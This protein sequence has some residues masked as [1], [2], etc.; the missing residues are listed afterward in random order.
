MIP[1]RNIL[2][3]FRKAVFQPGYAFDVFCRRFR[4]YLGYLFLNGRGVFP[5]SITL[6][7]TSRC[8]LRCR[9][10]G[11]WGD[12]GITK[13][14]HTK[15]GEELTLD[16][17]K[18]MLDD[19]S[20]FMPNITLFGG[21]PLL[22]KGCVEL[23]RLCKLR[24]MHVCL[25]TNGTLLKDYA[26]KIVRY[27]LDEL[28]ISLD[29][30]EEVHDKIRGVPGMF[31][32]IVMG[33]NE[34]SNEKQRYKKR[35]PIVNLEFTITRYNLDYMAEMQ[36]VAGD[37]NADSLNF[38]H[39]IFIE[40]E[41]YKR[42]QKE[43]YTIFKSSS[44]AWK[45]FLLEGIKDIDIDRLSRNIQ[46]ITSNRHDFLV[47]IYPN[48]TSDELETYYR[49]PEKVPHG[50]KARCI[51]PWIVAYIFPNGDVRPCLNFDFSPGNIKKNSFRDIWNNETYIRFR[52]V[53]KRKGIFPVCTRCT[54]LY[55]Y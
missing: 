39:L 19:V 20:G 40:E 42:H 47:N 48:L 50:Y 32:K 6:F 16:E 38:H 46:E 53:L 4:S 34:I 37:L 26:G 8:N 18:V 49:C 52:R 14:R 22:Y 24:K 10:C 21:E 45:G 11:Q 9:M 17:Y 33:L 29:G 35:R 30:P 41:M 44:D 55:R 54:E 31:R 28:N 13:D 12:K 5:E 1:R 23:I 27:G 25:I 43:F 3:N 51:S 7:L 36:K 15:G 2:R